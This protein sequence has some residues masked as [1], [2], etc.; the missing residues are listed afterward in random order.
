MASSRK[1][2]DEYIKR[3]SG[4]QK[5]AACRLRELIMEAVPDAEES[6]KWA[7]PVF[8]SNGPFAY[9]K[10]AKHHVTFGF[11]RGAELSDPKAILEGGDR[12][13][14]VKLASAKDID[15]AVLTAFVKEAVELNRT[16][17]NPTKR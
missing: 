7:Q 11:W 14:H 6:I 8:E 10:P 2:V 5:E 4:P 17:G 13:K 1:T 12:M 16:R 15:K 3:V 9:I